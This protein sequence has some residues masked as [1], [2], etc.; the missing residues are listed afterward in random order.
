MTRD[1]N[2]WIALVLLAALAAWQLPAQAQPRVYNQAELD[3]LLAPV[4]LYPDEVLSNILVA[5]TYP[6]DVRQAAEWSRANAQLS[7]EDAVRAAEAMPW[8]PSI[9]ALVAFPD[10]LGR[11]N[12]SPQW[13]ADLGAAFREQ[14]PYVM[15]TVQRL[16]RRAQ[17]NGA[18][19]SNDQYT[20]QQQG[21]DLAVYPAQPQVVYVPYYDP[22]VVY[23]T[24]WWPAYRPVFWRPW[25]PRPALFVSTNFVVRSVDWR[26]RHIVHP[27]F[28]GQVVRQ[29]VRTI[30]PQPVIQSH[31]PAQ[32]YIQSRGQPY[33]QNHTAAPA[34]REFHR[35]PPR[36][37]PQAPVAIPQQQAMRSIAA[38][39]VNQ[40]QQP[41]A[42]TQQP[43][44]RMQQPIART[45]QPIARMQQPVVRAFSH[46]P[47]AQPPRMR[48]PVGQAPQHGPRM[49][50]GN[51]QRRG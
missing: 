34:R 33:I 29:A 37:A 43:I 35:E 21:P 16:R 32:P 3:A 7:G 45:Q 44:A 15:D 42:R 12:E 30:Q 28:H 9:K 11:M 10:V 1:M 13:V 4:A 5:S 39:V 17:A 36:A 31:T 38:T 6:D 51:F 41:I 40:S 49:Q 19:Q 18:L 8:H 23:G 46:Q 22:Y 48:A 20:V 50:N 26:Q 14:E 25:Y 47:A 24:W 27:T 2:R